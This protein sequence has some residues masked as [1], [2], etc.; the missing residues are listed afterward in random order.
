MRGRTVFLSV[1]LVAVALSVLTA[2]R[3]MPGPD[4]LGIALAFYCLFV[5]PGLLLTRFASARI[6]T[7]LERICIVFA[8]SLLFLS[9]L[10]WIGGLPGMS[11]R[12]VGLTAAAAELVML[13]VVYRRERSAAE[14]SPPIRASSREG[15]LRRNSFGAAVVTLLLFAVC[16]VF[17][18]GTGSTG[19][20]TDSLDH[21]SYIRR[22]L[23]SG[24]LFPGD[25][26]YAGGD[27]VGFDPRKGLWHPIMALWIWQSDAPVEAVW[28]SAPSFLAFFA[29]VFFS[30]FVAVVTG[31]S[32]Y[33]FLAIPML[34]LFY[35][36]EGI[37]WFTK[38][39]YSRN[40]AQV[41]LWGGAAF[42]L[43]YLERAR[44]RHLAFVFFAALIGS[45]IHIVTVLILAAFCVA[46]FVY[47]AFAAPGR[48]WRDRFWK[49]LPVAA[50]GA[51]IP[52]ALRMIST[53]RTFNV[54][55]THRQGMLEIS[56]RLAMIDP[57]ELLFGTSPAFLFAF[58]MLPVFFFASAER[59]RRAL[60]GTLFAVPALIVI[61]PLAGALLE[62]IF[63]YLHFR[64]L[65]AAP[66]FCYLSILV[67]GLFRALLLGRFELR[68]ERTPGAVTRSEIGMRRRKPGS[69]GIA[70]AIGARIFALVLISAFLALPVR[71]AL[72]PTVE[73]ARR[74]LG[75]SELALPGDH[76]RL[77]EKLERVLPP[78]SIIASD[79][80]TSYVVSA[81]TSHFVVVTLD[82]HGSPAD[83]LALERLE[84]VRDLFNPEVP[85]RESAEW[86]D[87]NAVG[88]IL[89][90]ED[91][92]RTKDFFDTFP[93]GS[94]G[95]AYEK[96]GSG[97]RIC[98]EID[99]VG[100]FRLFE[101][102]REALASAAKER[103]AQ[104]IADHV[105]CDDLPEPRAASIVGAEGV[106]MDRAV[107]ESGRC[108]PGDTL[109][110]YFCWRLQHDLAFGMPLE[111]TV[112]IERDFPKGPFYRRWYSKQYRRRVERREEQFY[113]YT[114]SGSIHSGF[115]TPDQWSPGIGHR[116][117]FQIP[118]S[119]WLAPGVYEVRAS[120]SR[121]SYLP[122]RSISDYLL[123]EDSLH[124][125]AVGSLE[126]GSR[127]SEDNAGGY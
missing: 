121:L 41:L 105:T 76:R 89:L 65:Y 63:G 47:T 11:Y 20:D 110:G 58:A 120:V 112:R 122:N 13:L 25:S 107:F 36:G 23:D 91:N 73:R 103:D 29:L 77:A 24:A 19:W 127:S 33:L 101:I 98:T 1:N 124:G 75:K 15:G 12:E 55:H 54:I 68:V 84:A 97:A 92:N 52:A 93:L 37:A 118:I 126:I 9:I 28:L 95:P 106:L 88:Y 26:Y 57:A 99:S 72:S 69:A 56:D 53:S 117:D 123:N 87:E 22:S 42:S 51:V 7:S 62:Q 64:I 80:R 6:E 46:L 70:A 116:Q 113:R 85:L 39:G 32:R 109:R 74:I 81:Y 45:A 79:P 2:L 10:V 31:R 3:I 115:T 61:N 125:E 67:T 49:L 8:A 59:S 104:W 90:C 5:L 21:I 96:L 50:A 108:A 71:L 38:I 43:E 34:L 60:I 100:Y 78:Y 83:T 18:Y 111:W 102:D 4:I 40:I 30:W 27:G 48:Q 16:F 86:L 44:T 119:A 82:Q 35:R 66:L 17:F 94:A 14:G 114:V